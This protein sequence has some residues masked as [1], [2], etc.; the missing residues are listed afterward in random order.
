MALLR[1]K[2]IK[3]MSVEDRAKMQADSARLGAQAYSERTI[4]QEA[5]SKAIAEDNAA[6]RGCA[7]EP[8]S[9]GAP[10]GPPTAR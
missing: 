8:V 10:K 9:G 6:A 3:A 7:E 1:T 5:I 2:E 4:S